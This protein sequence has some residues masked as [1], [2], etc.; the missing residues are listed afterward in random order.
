MLL[1]GL[2]FLPKLYRAKQHAGLKEVDL[3]ILFTHLLTT[4]ATLMGPGGAKAVVADS[5]VMKQQLVI[6]NR[7]RRRA[8]ILVSP[9]SL[10][11]RAG[12]LRSK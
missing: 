12:K 9:G 4:I 8:P 3:L 10:L 1:I 11:A 5:L 6:V 2:S 7:A